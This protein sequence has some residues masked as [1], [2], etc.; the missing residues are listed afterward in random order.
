MNKKIAGIHLYY[1]VAVLVV[2]IIAIL[3]GTFMDLQISS[4]LAHIGNVFGKIFA[5][6]GKY[7]GY[8]IFGSAG[9]LFYVYKKDDEEKGSKAWAYAFLIAIPLAVG[10]L[11]G[12][13]DLTELIS[14]K[15]VAIFLGALAIGAGEVGMYFLFRRANKEEAYNAGMAFLFSAVLVFVT[16]YLLKNAALRPRYSWL[17]SVNHL[18]YYQTWYAFNSSIKEA[19]STVDSSNFMSWPSSHVA[20]ASLAVLASLFPRLNKKLEGKEW[21]CFLVAAL[22]ILIVAIARVSD[23]SHFLSDVGWGTL[24]GTGFSLLVVSL[25]YPSE[26]AKEKEPVAKE[27]PIQETFI[28][29]PITPKPIEPTVG[30]TSEP[31]PRKESPTTIVTP[32]AP[33]EP[34]KPAPMK[35]EEPKG[36][37]KKKKKDGFYEI[38][39]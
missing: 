30:K 9:V 14:N 29:A 21:L 13:D 24:I 23:G 6:V 36:K 12:Y 7:P 37:E 33:V 5:V 38:D 3:V 15:I 11:Y 4:S 2:A 17:V 39:S 25:V 19:N 16:T 1:F 35:P 32:P 8:L 34:A 18:D 27:T 10:A 28:S 20:M 22:W 26:G 31:A